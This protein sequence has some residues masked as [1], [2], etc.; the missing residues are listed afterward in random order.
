MESNAIEESKVKIGL[1]QVLKGD[2]PRLQ[3]LQVNPE[4][5]CNH[6]CCF[7]TY[8]HAGFGEAEGLEFRKPEWFDGQHEHVVEGVS[9]MPREMLLGLGLDI[10]A[11]EIPETEITGG[12]ESMLN[13]HIFDFFDVLN[14]GDSRVTLVTNGTKLLRAIPHVTKNWDWVRVSINAGTPET[15]HRVH[16]RNT[17]LRALNDARSVREATNVPVYV[18]YC[19]IPENVG[20]IE[21]MAR[22]AKAHG[23]SGIKYNAIY[24]STMDGRMSES[25]ADVAREQIALA[26]RLKDEDFEVMD[27]FWKRERY[28]DKRKFGHCYFQYF[29]ANIAPDG[30]V[31]PCC[32]TTAR[33]KYAYGDL[34]IQ[35]LPLILD[36]LGRRQKAETYNSNTCPQCWLGNHNVHMESIV[37]G[38]MQD[39]RMDKE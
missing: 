1:E 26:Q 7:C 27:S 23:L 12:G 6:N 28:R 18:S 34:K 17:F 30:K 29:I 13:P 14:K 19:V 8:R 20:E 35:R 39:M 16:G 15:Y 37:D 24:T 38:I 11:L 36:S 2:F 22:L 10:N 4:A 5:A 33:P 9:G 21:L 3:K 31:Y 25:Q 32:I